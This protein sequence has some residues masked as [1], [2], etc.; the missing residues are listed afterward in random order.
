M[1]RALAFLERN[2]E[3]YVVAAILGTLVVLLASQV[4]MRYVV[5]APF[6][7]SE[8]L[9]RYLLIWCTFIG[10]SLAVREGRNIS[11]DLLPVMLGERWRRPFA[12]LANVGALAFFLVIIFASI[13]LIGRIAA[14]GQSSP[15]LGI[16]MW[17]IYAA[18]PVGLGLAAVRAVQSLWVMLMPGKQ[19]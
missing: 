18:V 8:E 14:I 12:V 11:V 15:G 2:F 17:M 9:A 7:W 1:L 6:V 13:P 19:D 3:R 16:P 4:F 10:V 5:R